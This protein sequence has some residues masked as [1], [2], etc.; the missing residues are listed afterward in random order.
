MMLNWT[1]ISILK[2]ICRR[3]LRQIFTSIDMTRQDGKNHFRHF[4]SVC[5]CLTSVQQLITTKRVVREKILLRQDHVEIFLTITQHLGNTKVFYQGSS[6]CQR[7]LKKSHLPPFT[8]F[9]VATAEDNL[10]VVKTL[11]GTR[12]PNLQR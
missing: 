5:P 3:S 9:K 4:S 11:R 8:I 1:Q 12:I 7:K 2:C 10:E 6:D